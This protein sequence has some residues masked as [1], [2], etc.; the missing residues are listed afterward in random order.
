MT[1]IAA[2]ELRK[3]GRG[4]MFAVL[5]ETKRERDYKLMRIPDGWTFWAHYCS[6]DEHGNIGWA[7]ST[8]GYFPAGSKWNRNAEEE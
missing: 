5:E 6:W 2:G 4:E 3:N 1:G 8:G 7:Y